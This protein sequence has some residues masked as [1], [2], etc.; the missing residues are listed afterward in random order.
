MHR[1]TSLA[2][3]LPLVLS[4]AAC[5]G[6]TPGADTPKTD[7]TGAVFQPTVPEGTPVYVNRSGQ[8]LPAS[9][10]RQTGP[11][12]VLV[13]YEGMPADWDEDVIF[14]RVRSREV[15]APAA[16]GF[17]AGEVVLVNV[18]NRIVMAEVAQPI[19]AG[20]FRVHFSGY[21][22]EVVQ[23]VAAA[24]IS[25][26]F[27]GA[28][29]HATGASVLVDVGAPQAYPAKVLAAVA[30]DRWL[31]RLDNAGPQYD[32]V[33]DAAHIHA[34]EAPA[35]VAPPVVAPPV[36]TATPDAGKPPAAKPP[37]AKPP[38]AKPPVVDTTPAAPA[39]LKAGDAALVMIRSVWYPAKIV[40]AGAAAGS[41]KVRVEGATADEE[42]AG[43]HVVR[44]EDPLK[45]VKYKVG[46]TV[47]VEWHGVY[48][49][50]KVV[51]DAGSANY[52][53]RPDGKG[54]EADE[55]IPAKRL[56]PR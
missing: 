31:V 5:T 50:G 22:P 53:V 51:K 29:A 14:D 19:D 54:S 45:G 18:Q 15:A 23:N 33:V 41:F 42:I 35:P 43:A 20:N 27:A 16:A 39:P 37:A 46:Q 40:G 10:V 49:P 2:L 6:T 11:T 52:V 25:R 36:A 12:N 21:G 3:A 7:G 32:Q 13:H 28:T 38:A 30:A 8:W 17:K 24:Q 56:R 9:V 34:A 48:A 1:T 44:M 55:V 47:F 4:L 26:P